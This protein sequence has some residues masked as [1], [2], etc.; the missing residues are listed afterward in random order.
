MVL[1]FPQQTEVISVHISH[2]LVFISDKAFIFFE[3]VTGYFMLKV[4][5]KV[6]LEMTMKIQS[7]SRGIAL[8]FL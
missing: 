1:W 8:R 5:V 2:R 7:E 6:T 3:V 4:K